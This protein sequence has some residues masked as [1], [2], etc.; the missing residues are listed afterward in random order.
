M[1]IISVMSFTI[2]TGVLFKGYQ[3]F[4]LD[5]RCRET[6][7]SVVATL[8]AASVMCLLAQVIT[9]SI[10]PWRPIEVNPAQ[11]LSQAF[12]LFNA[13]FYW[14]LINFMQGRRVCSATRR[15]VKHHGI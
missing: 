14:T 15:E 7:K 8:M 3:F 1:L 11:S 6:D 12:N 10:S 5:E 13:I 9:W 4:R 2:H